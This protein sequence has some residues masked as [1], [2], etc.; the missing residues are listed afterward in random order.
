MKRDTTT[1][2]WKDT[3]WTGLGIHKYQYALKH[4]GGDD[5]ILSGIPI[6]ALK[7]QY[8]HSS[9]FMT[10]KYA[11]KIKGIYKQQIIDNSPEF[12]EKKATL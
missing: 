9:K 7:E 5:K 4:T 12:G 11:K 6:D 1:R 3:V 10:E 8:G 2:F